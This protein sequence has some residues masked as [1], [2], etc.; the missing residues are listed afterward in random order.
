[1]IV[2]LEEQLEKARK[3]EI[4]DLRTYLLPKEESDLKETP[5]NNT[6][7]SLERRLHY[8]RIL[9]TI[10][11]EGS[12]A[13]P[14]NYMLL[15]QAY[16]VIRDARTYGEVKIA[17]GDTPSSQN[18]RIHNLRAANIAQLGGYVALEEPA[19]TKQKERYC[20]VP[21]KITPKG[22][23]IL[24]DGETQKLTYKHFTENTAQIV[25]QKQYAD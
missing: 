23:A 7:Q 13:L 11:I 19:P 25:A 10:G 21:A 5:E 14:F 4:D 20:T 3:K 8:R 18:L 6:D 1:M 2:S 17:L 9:D 12:Q 24:E 15:C 16:E 22:R